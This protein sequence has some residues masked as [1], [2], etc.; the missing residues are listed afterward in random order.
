[1]VKQTLLFIL[2][3][4]LSGC[5]PKYQSSPEYISNCQYARLSGPVFQFARL[6]SHKQYAG[7]SRVYTYTNRG[8][9]NLD[10]ATY[11]GQKGKLTDEISHR[12]Y[13]NPVYFGLSGTRCSAFYACEPDSGSQDFYLTKAQREHRAREKRF[14]VRKA[15]LE[16]CQ[17]VYIR[18]DAL[19]K[20][21]LDPGLIDSAGL[22][23][24]SPI[25]TKPRS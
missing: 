11:L 9:H 24:L 2:L 7:Y 19:S 15:I 10:Y 13:G 6:P 22:R 5:L 16:N 4:T 17:V 1:M 3:G 14:V 21:Y 20:N 23:L 8:S 25:I 12:D 18:I